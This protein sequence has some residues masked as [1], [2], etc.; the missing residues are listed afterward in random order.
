M[1]RIGFGRGDA[2]DRRRA[3]R[4]RR[5]SR[6]PMTTHQA[7][8]LPTTSSTLA[9]NTSVAAMLS[10][11]PRSPWLH[12]CRDSARPLRQRARCSL[13]LSGGSSAPAEP[14]PVALAARVRRR[15]STPTIVRGAARD[16][17]PAPRRDRTC[18]DARPA[19]D[20][21]S[22]AGRGRAHTRPGHL[23]RRIAAAE[24]AQAGPF[25]VADAMH[26][27]ALPPL[28][29]SGR[30]FAPAARHRPGEQREPGMCT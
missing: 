12:R 6:A 13:P 16:R 25:L 28:A 3:T 7:G 22:P 9:T 26:G 29:A 23:A 20:R 21:S 11:R 15:R 8:A 19:I 18:G 30:R 1:P 24:L 10:A 27:G 14:Q 2:A 5:G 4:Q 17:R